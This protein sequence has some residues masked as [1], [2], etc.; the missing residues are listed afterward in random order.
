[1][2]MASIIGDAQT[3]TGLDRQLTLASSCS[4]TKDLNDD[5]DDDDDDELDFLSPR[6][7][8]KPSDDTKVK[9]TQSNKK[10]AKQ[11][12]ITKDSDQEAIRLKDKTKEPAWIEDQGKN[13]AEFKVMIDVTK[14][15]THLRSF[16]YSFCR[17]F[18]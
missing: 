5:D 11:S 17:S 13:N 16:S 14:I 3:D 15:T 2:A 6:V 12:R 18:S 1:M 4:S 10:R 7:F 8:P 9:S